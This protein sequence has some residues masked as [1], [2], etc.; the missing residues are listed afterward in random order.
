MAMAGL[1]S[2]IRCGLA[3]MAIMLIYT[4]SPCRATMYYYGAQFNLPVPALDETDAAF[5]KGA[6]KTAEINIADH[7]HIA[8]IDVYI[9]LR[10]TSL[11][12]LDITLTSPYGTTVVLMRSGNTALLDTPGQMVLAFSD[13]ASLSLANAS[14]VSGQ[15]LSKPALGYS[16]STFQ[17]QDPYGTWKLDV[18]DKIYYSTGTLDSVRLVINNPE[19]ATLLLMLFGFTLGKRQF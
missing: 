15:A 4:A 11:A 5:G 14:I 10:H 13:R 9:S 6:M 12:D 3:F 8:A 1:N 18:S 17:G 7:R 19:P 16:L 2:S